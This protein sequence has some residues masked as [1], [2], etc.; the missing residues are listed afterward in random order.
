[1][2]FDM[3]TLPVVALAALAVSATTGQDTATAPPTPVE[4]VRA[5]AE[6]LAPQMRSD[7]VRRFLGATA[8]LPEID[9]ERTVWWNRAERRALRPD[10]VDA[11]DEAQLDGFRELSLGPEFYYYTAYGTPLAYARALDLAAAHGFES[12][13]GRRI[14][15]FGFG[16][17]GHLR[18]LASLG[19]H[20]T[21]IE[22][23]ELLR[24]FYREPGDTGTIP[25]SAAAPPGSPGT[26]TLL[27]GSFP[28]DA[29]ILRAAG[30][31]Y[32]LVLSKN[33]LKLGYVHPER[34]ADPRRLVHLGVDDE[35]FVRAV[36][37]LL[38]P[39]GLFVIYNLYPQ[40]APPDEAYI[41]HA[42]GGCPFDRGLVESVGS[43]IV[44]FNRA[45]TAAA[46]RMGEA[47]GWA[48]SMDLETDLFGMYT[49]FRR[50]G[51]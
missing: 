45:D 14:L 17:I 37:D 48:D 51:N 5:E 39:G 4:M 38:N 20:V 7:L 21:G 15:D 12:A 24:E 18:L 36:H 40:Q 16:G 44:A 22:I 11:M 47:L 3:K 43:E 46:R 31:G 6:A 19:G 13:D 2:S 29:A 34:E 49:I 10:Q 8:D 23:L 27:Y 1:M 26:L 30:A 41:P 33:V 32:D 25:R 35:T 28:G 9:G 42:T 50:P